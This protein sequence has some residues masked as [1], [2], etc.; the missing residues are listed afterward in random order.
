MQQYRRLNDCHLLDS[1]THDRWRCL[2]LLS[3]IVTDKR[4]HR[5]KFMNTMRKIAARPEGAFALQKHSSIRIRDPGSLRRIQAKKKKR[6]ADDMEKSMPPFCAR[7]SPCVF[8]SIPTDRLSK[9]Y[10]TVEYR[11]GRGKARSCNGILLQDRG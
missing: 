5:A 10:S 4:T 3:Q 11:N 2:L 8:D 1:C 6:K 7:S 9:M